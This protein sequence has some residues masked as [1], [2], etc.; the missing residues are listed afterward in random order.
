MYK[1]KSLVVFILLAVTFISCQNEEHIV[2]KEDKANEAFKNWMK[3]DLTEIFSNKNLNY[4]I[5]NEKLLELTSIEN[6]SEIRFIPG[7]INNE[8]TIRITAV[9]QSQNFLRDQWVEKGNGI[10]ILD[11]LKGKN[12]NSEII[13]DKEV[14]SHKLSVEKTSRY[15][16]NWNLKTSDD[17]YDLVTYNGERL[18]FIAYPAKLIQHIAKLETKNTTITWGINDENKMTTVFLNLSLNRGISSYDDGSACPPYCPKEE[19]DKPE[20]N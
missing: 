14:A 3:A 17:I 9:D 11:Q 20:G 19:K 2:L 15:L 6:V 4:T 18:R 7:V 1:Q 5:D 8:L 12:M 13:T 10:N 16:Q